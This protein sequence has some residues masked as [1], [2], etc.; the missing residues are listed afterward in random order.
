MLEILFTVSPLFILIFLGS[1]LRILK[2]A[3]EDWIEVLNKF[4]LMVGFPAIIFQSLVNVDIGGMISIDILLY[5]LILLA[6]VMLSGLGITHALGLDTKIRNSYMMCIAFGNVAYLGYPFITSVLPNSSGSVSLHIAVY[7]FI[8]FTL[9][10]FILEISL[11]AGKKKKLDILKLITNCLKNPLLLAVIFGIGFLYFDI[12][13]PQVIDASLGMLAKSASPVVLLALGMFIAR[14]ISF[15]NSFTHATIIALLS[16][17]AMP[18]G[19]MAFGNLMQFG[20]AFQISILQAAMP[21]A[22]TPFALAE[23][24]P[25]DKKVIATAIMIST[26]G[27]VITL[28]YFVSIM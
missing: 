6:V 27:A 12:P 14:K 21:L 25:L 15:D 10:L 28:P 18:L 4:G 8:V 1:L 19:F 3:D 5:N 23:I 9:G 7:I 11:N 24:Y 17:I 2:I 26:V 13:I 22:I 16:L 20:S